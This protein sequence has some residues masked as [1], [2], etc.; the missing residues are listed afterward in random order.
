MDCDPRQGLGDS[1]PGVV[2]PPPP[3]PPRSTFPGSSMGG[4]QTSQSSM[5]GYPIS[6][7]MGGSNPWAATIGHSSYYNSPHSNGFNSYGGATSSFNS[8]AN[9]IPSGARGPFETVESVVHAVSSISMLLDSTYRSGFLKRDKNHSP[10][11]HQ[12]I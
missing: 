6:H 10:N 2:S 11:S 7:P 12:K 3:V 8:S 9:L 1:C 5:G 4:Y